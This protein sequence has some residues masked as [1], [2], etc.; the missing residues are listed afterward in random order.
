ME[1]SQKEGFKLYKFSPEELKIIKECG[2]ESF[3][4]RCLP[5]STV[6]GLAT[7]YGVKSGVFK[8]SP[9]FGAAPKVIVAGFVGYFLGKISYQAKCAERLMQLPNSPYGELLRQR[10]K[11]N[12]QNSSIDAGFG[13]SMSLAPFGGI[14]NAE[15]YPDSS[16]KTLDLD[17]SSSPNYS[18][19]DDSFRPSLDNPGYEEVEMPP[20][21]KHVTTYDELRTQNREEYVQKRTGTYKEAPKPA[22][23]YQSIP[24]PT[25]SGTTGKNKY[26]DDV[27]E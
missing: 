23:S 17:T 12:I 25:P 21:Q 4:Q 9:R 10:K 15:V 8:A 1:N 20:V 7:Y 11:G 22:P 14:S 19:L 18:G 26:G 13:P 27:M 3:F 24:R 5:L 16:S 2:K 6:L